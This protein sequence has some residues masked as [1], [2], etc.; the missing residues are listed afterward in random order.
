MFSWFTHLS[1][2]YNYTALLFLFTSLNTDITRTNLSNNKNSNSS[3]WFIWIFRKINVDVFW[4]TSVTLF[5]IGPKTGPNQHRHGI[6]YRLVNNQSA[7]LMLLLLSGILDSSEQ[8]I[9]NP[10]SLLVVL[11]RSLARIQR[12]FLCPSD[13]FYCLTYVLSPSFISFKL[14]LVVVSFLIRICCETFF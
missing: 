9:S 5:E 12:Y 4:A 2:L 1:F 13:M 10:N 8:E 6:L 7:G 14:N 11:A 3:Q